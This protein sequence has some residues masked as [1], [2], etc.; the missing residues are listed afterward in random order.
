MD[1]YE[2]YEDVNPL[3]E[4]KIR[5]NKPLQKDFFDYIERELRKNATDLAK[6]YYKYKDP[7]SKG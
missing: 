7:R 1:I 6:Y 4:P 2:D 3:M 5:L